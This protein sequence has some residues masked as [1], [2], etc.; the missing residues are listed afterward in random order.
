M[1]EKYRNKVKT[2]AEAAK[3]VQSGDWVD[4]GF[5]NGFPEL[6]DEA[7]AARKEELQDV[8][9]RGGLVYRPIIHTIDCDPEMKHFQYYSWHLGGYERK[10]FTAR[11]LHF[12]PMMLRLLPEMYRDYLTVDVAVVPVSRPDANG[13]CGL[14]LAS[15]CW[16]TIMKKARTV[17]F[18]IN[19]HMPTLQGVDGSHRVSLDEAD[20]IVEGEHAPLCTSGYRTPSEADLQIA[21]NVVA[22]IPNG[23][24]L[25]LGVGTIPFTIAQ[26]LAQSDR[27][28]L[29]CHTG[30]ISDAFLA[31]TGKRT[32]QVWPPGTWPAVPRNCMT[33]S[34]KNRSCSIRRKWIMSTIPGS[35][36][37]SPTTSASTAGCSWI[38]WAR[39]MPNPSGPGSCP[40]WAASWTSWKGP[41]CPMGEPATSASNPPGW[42]RKGSV[43][44]TSSRPL[45]PAAP[46]PV[47]GH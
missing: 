27:E 13:Y 16:K 21:R 26:I 25:S 44:P 41:S 3:A 31:P 15:Y 11:R 10:M 33:G 43:I 42:T 18:E 9:I 47:P 37:R 28:D 40:E 30:T 46:S 23:A 22:E 19:E 12:V 14:G 32:R 2:P 5:G 4:F 1:L 35:W 6:M 8:K 38:S 7:L 36:K 45:P 29:G 34:R 24:T 39:K 17:I 20:I